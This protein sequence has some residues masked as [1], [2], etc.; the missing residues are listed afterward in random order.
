MHINAFPYKVKHL[1]VM[2]VGMWEGRSG[3]IERWKRDGREFTGV[4]LW[5]LDSFFYLQLYLESLM[6][7]RFFLNRL[8]WWSMAH[9][10]RRTQRRLS[11][12]PCTDVSR[13]WCHAAHS[14]E[15][16]MGIWELF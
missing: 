13:I 8:V 6:I 1:K 5:A 9:Q 2:G 15:N 7:K 4:Y 10:H 3:W 11:Q 12:H 16:E 14:H